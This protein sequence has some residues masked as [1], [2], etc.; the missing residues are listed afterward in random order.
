[1]KKFNTWMLA[2]AGI[3]L[4]LFLILNQITV[5]KMPMGGTITAGAMVP[6]LIFSFRWGGKKGIF[7]CAVAGI[8][9][10]IIGTKYSFHPV[11]L[12][13][14]YPIAYGMIGL[15]GFFSKKIKGMLTGTVVGIF[16]RF[17]CHVLSGV[18]VFASY[19]PEGQSPLIY[20]ILYNGTYLLPEL[21]IS[22]IFVTLIIKY[23]RLPEPK[24]A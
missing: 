10:F 8:M 13:F 19:A 17:L 21:I 5:L 7:V 24:K 15:A 16:G 9:D 11:S 6:L 23:A 4:A 3:V 12:L 1:M 2:E 18:V 20:S 22:F 14:D